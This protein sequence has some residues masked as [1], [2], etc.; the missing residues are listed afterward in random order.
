MRFREIA[1][2][3]SADGH[4]TQP[5]ARSAAAEIGK[6]A[7]ACTHRPECPSADAVDCEAARVLVHCPV[8]GYSLLCNGVLAFEDT[9]CLLPSG[10]VVSHRRFLPLVADAREAV[11]P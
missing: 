7:L 11:D 5:L 10:R 3:D 6:V 1:R 8:L 9:G 4:T 2:G